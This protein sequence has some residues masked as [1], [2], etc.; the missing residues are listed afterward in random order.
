MRP[1]LIKILE[2]GYAFQQQGQLE[3]AE[4]AYLQALDLDL[5]NEFALNLMG[6]ICIKRSQNEKA[7]EYLQQALSV[8]SADT[9]THNNLG[10]AY[11]GLKKFAEARQEFEHSLALNAAQPVTLNNLGN[12]LAA[13]DR[14][15][16]AIRYFES[17][18][19]INPDY[20]DC[21]NNLSVSL[22]EVGR[23]DQALNVIDHA[24]RISNSSSLSHNNKGEIL[25]RAARYELARMSF[26][27]A[28]ET[29]GNIVAKV[30]LSTALK[31][32]GEEQAAEQVLQEVLRI[33]PDNAEAQNHLGVLYEQMGD[34]ALAAKH[35]RLALEHAPNHASSYFQ[36]SK[37]KD[38][39][40]TQSEIEKIHSLLQQPELLGIF[41]SSLFFALAWEFE[42]RK[43]YKTSIEYF[44]KAQEIKAAR[45]PY[46]GAATLE[47]L[48]VSRC[49]FPVERKTPTLEPDGQPI[50]VF[51]IGMPRSGTTLTEQIISSHSEIT[52]AGELGFINDIVKQA[53]DMTRQPFPDAIEALTSEQARKLRNAYLSRLVERFGHSR[54]VV[55]KNPLNYNFVGAIATI[56][57][58][59]RILFCKRDPMDNC[60]SIFRLPFDD[61]QGYSHGLA[62]LGHHYRQ[63]EKLMEHWLDC[64][65]DQIL[66]VEYEQ[67]VENLESQA[68]RMLDFIGVEFEEQV[69][70][71][72][73]NERI[74][75]TPS[76]EQ[77]RLPIYRSSIGA[78]KRYG[79]ALDPL[80]VA[81]GY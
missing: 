32:L 66:T 59:A 68:R 69:L 44:I 81:L 38:Q 41:R 33:E 13:V 53:S 37:L 35:F 8:N 63:H 34:T 29:D 22:K 24:I 71:F 64:Y 76:A 67:T 27:H 3:A 48:R 31:Q 20:V 80:A 55:D 5:S 11:K 6:V 75:M 45:H 51:V 4:K 12:V 72:F 78:W 14:H 47:Y 10:L 7:V 26:E 39:R 62:S 77:V 74:V 49:I 60:V 79:Q 42:K 65:A 16:E 18:L 2:R 61:T 46:D 1:D 23:L 28:I 15:D 73:D 25:L 17:A 30:N 21:L 70:R 50:P 43:D 40:L 58:E 54:F 52:G 56:F 19:A 9:E 57:P 36:L